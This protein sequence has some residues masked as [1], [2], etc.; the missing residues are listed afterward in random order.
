MLFRS[1][2][3]V[4]QSRYEPTA[5]K[6]HPHPIHNPN[7][8]LRSHHPKTEQQQH[9]LPQ[10]RNELATSEPPPLQ[11]TLPNQPRNHQPLPKQNKNTKKHTTNPKPLLPPN[12]PTLTHKLQRL[13]LQKQLNIITLPTPHNKP[14]Q[15]NGLKDLK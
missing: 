11:Q 4:S 9:L 10:H 14:F 12:N 13:P 5:T 6:W 3:S 15:I 2:C 1:C 8:Q 7:T